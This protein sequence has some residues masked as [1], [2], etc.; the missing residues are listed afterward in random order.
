MKCPKGKFID[1]S[2]FTFCYVAATGNYTVGTGNITRTQ[3]PAGTTTSGPG[4]YCS[5]VGCIS[6]S[7]ECNQAC[8]NAT[9]VEECKK[10]VPACGCR[11]TSNICTKNADCDDDYFC[12]FANNTNCY[13]SSVGECKKVSDYMPSSSTVATTTA[14]GKTWIR[15]TGMNWWSAQNWCK[16]QGKKPVSRADIGCGDNLDG[17]Y[18][19]QSGTVLKAIQDTTWRG[20]GSHWLEDFGNSCSAY[21]VTFD[22][23]YV[24]YN[25]RYASRYALCQ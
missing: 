7:A 14:A 22:S 18:C 6:D 2:G 16:A 17:T 12:W 20:Y 15:S 25:G 8:S 21:N 5:S 11:A 19:M 10:G 3:C 24:S 9:N 13:S 1:H 23:S 4:Y